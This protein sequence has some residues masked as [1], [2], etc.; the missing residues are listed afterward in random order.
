MGR[1]EGG[2]RGTGY[3]YTHKLIHFMVQQKLTH[4]KATIP[5]LKKKKSRCKGLVF[6]D[7]TMFI[8]P[9]FE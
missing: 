2:P 4:Y 5:Q 1:W 8:L 7:E 9:G 6:P 3:M